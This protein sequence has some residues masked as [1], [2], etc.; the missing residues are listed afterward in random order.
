MYEYL[1]KVKS[2]VDSLEAVG[3]HVPLNDYIEAIFNGLPDEYESVITTVLSKTESY[4]IDEIEALLLSQE[5][6]LERKMHVQILDSNKNDTSGSITVSVAQIKNLS[7]R[8]PNGGFNG[9]PFNSR[10]RGGHQSFN[11]R[12]GRRG[13]R[14]SQGNYQGSFQGSQGNQ[15]SAGV[16]KQQLVCQLCGNNG[17]GVWNCYHKFDPNF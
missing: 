12:Y 3:S 13:G 1:L 17:H 6:K 16:L 15:Y 2:I 11:N 10:G 8:G 5:T 7:A 9:S 14:N 4:T